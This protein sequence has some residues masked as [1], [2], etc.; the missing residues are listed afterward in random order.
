[1]SDHRERKLTQ[2]S[3]KLFQERQK[4]FAPPGRVKV[5]IAVKLH[6]PPTLI[7]VPVASMLLNRDHMIRPP[8][9]TT[10]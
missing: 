1:M 3:D 5:D 8:M 9:I 7:G 2:G 4:R 6:N 10:F